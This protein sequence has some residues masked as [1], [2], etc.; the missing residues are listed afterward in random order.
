MVEHHWVVDTEDPNLRQD[1]SQVVDPTLVARAL[2]PRGLLEFVEV[3]MPELHSPKVS[4]VVDMHPISVLA[5]MRLRD[6]LRQHTY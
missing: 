2:L 3:D 1:E 5:G 4:L 6:F